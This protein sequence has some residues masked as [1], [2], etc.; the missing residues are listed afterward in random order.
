MIKLPGTAAA[1]ATAPTRVFGMSAPEFRQ[2]VRAETPAEWL[3]DRP[4]IG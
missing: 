2:R 1:R 3:A 4:R